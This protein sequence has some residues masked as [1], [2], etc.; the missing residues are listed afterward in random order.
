MAIPCSPDTRNSGFASPTP[1][2]NPQAEKISLRI[3]LLPKLLT[4]FGQVFWLV[5]L[6]TDRAFPCRFVLSG[7]RHSGFLRGSSSL[8]AAGPR[9][10]YTDFP[11]QT[12]TD[13]RIIDE[14]SWIPVAFVKQR[15]V[16]R[17]LPLQILSM[18]GLINAYRFL[19][20]EKGFHVGVSREARF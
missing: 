17:A 5:D 16:S 12:C 6:P 13:Q 8:T 1:N 2:K 14:V 20:A 18:R 19:R 7:L 9:R 11:F 3:Y 15:V 4:R 10:S